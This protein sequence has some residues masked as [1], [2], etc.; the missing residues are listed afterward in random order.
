MKYIILVPD[1]MADLPLDE[2]DSKTPWQAARTPN[3]DKLAAESLVG[4]SMTVPAG[5]YP[6]SD[7]A[8]MTLLGYDPRKFYTGRGAIEAAAMGLNLGAK[9]AA[10]RC[11]LVTCDGETMIDYS[12][13]HITTEEARELIGLVNDKLGSSLIK[14]FPGVSYRHIM[15]WENGSIELKTTPPHDISGQ[16]IEAH[17]PVGDGDEK[18]RQLM[19]DSLELLDNHPINRRRRSEGHNPGNMIWLWGQGYAPVMPGFLRTYGKQGAVITAV[20]VIRGL[21]NLVGLRIITVPGATGYLDTNYAGKARAAVEALKSGLDFVFVHIEAPDECGHEGNID[22]KIQAIQDIDQLVL[23]SIL[24]GLRK[25]D[26]LRILILP[27]HATPIA[28]KTHKEGPVPFLLFD[29][30]AAHTGRHFPFD[31]RAIDEAST[32]IDDGTQLIRML[33]EK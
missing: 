25:F 32:Q 22:G 20:D 24:E 17:L 13:G 7:A 15:A 9:D 31:E 5:M 3:F 11:S 29:S 14:F 10:F 2:L 30:R 23:G 28:L 16:S 21:A 27:D 26:D 18:L 33:F 12:S 1:G 8:N 4:A 6:G 19:F